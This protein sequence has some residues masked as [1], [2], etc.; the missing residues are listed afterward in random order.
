VRDHIGAVT[1]LWKAHN[2]VSMRLRGDEVA[3]GS[4]DRGGF[5]RKLWPTVEACPSC[6]KEEWRGNESIPS[7]VTSTE[8]NDEQWDTHLVFEYHQEVF[9]FE[10]DTFVCSGFDDTSRDQDTRKEH[11]DKVNTTDTKAAKA[12]KGA[13]KKMVPPVETVKA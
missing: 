1:W 2:A 4:E 5:P 13:A 3:E 10:S 7:K 12:P 9:C 6:Y 8:E 11:Q